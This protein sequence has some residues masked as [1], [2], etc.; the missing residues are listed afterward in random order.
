MTKHP[1]PA[2]NTR[3]GFHYFP[4]TLHYRDSDLN[5]WLPELKALGAKWLTLVAPQDRA[6]PESFIRGII[7]AGIE[8]VL[9]FHLTMKSLP[10]ADSLSLLF[11]VYADWG[12]QY[13]ALFNRPNCHSQWSDDKWVQQDLVERFLDIYIPLCETVCHAGLT[14]VFPPLEPGGDFWDTAFLRTSLQS[15]VRRG[16]QRLLDRLV[17]GAYA[18]AENLPLNWGAG[19]PERWPGAR[20]YYTPPEEEDHKGFRIFDWYTTISEAVLEEKLPILLLAAGVRPGD[21]RDLNVPAVDAEE[22]ANRNL[23]LARHLAGDIETIH[24]DIR[25]EPIPEH[26]LAGNFWLLAAAQNSPEAEASWYKVNGTTL[27]IVQKIKDWVSGLGEGQQQSYDNPP[28]QNHRANHK[29]NKPIKHYLLL[30]AYEWG[31]ANWHLEITRPFIKKHM[32]TVGFSMQEA[33]TAEKVT[34][35]GGEQSFPPEEVEQLRA[36]GCLVEQVSGDGTSIATQLDKL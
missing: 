19:G 16:H 3:I 22:H 13:V 11:Q 30:P 36:V 15:L 28:R 14:S 25:L 10:R 8:P 12:V 6:I 5:A 20:P 7:D 17:L 1:T 23:I 26:V 34:I 4:D 31:V 29:K 2:N 32:P 24:D 27:P 18:W 35:V 21:Q 33:S 9:H